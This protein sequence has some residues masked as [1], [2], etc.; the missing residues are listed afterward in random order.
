MTVPSK[1]TLSALRQIVGEPFVTTGE[2][3]LLANARD[4]WPKG[5]IDMRSGKV[6]MRPD[7]VVRPGTPEEVAKILALASRLRIPVTPYAEG[8]GVCGGAVPVRGGISLD[9]KRLN[10]LLEID[11]ES[12]LAWA[13]CGINGEKFERALGARGF[14]LGHFP[15]SIYCS[16]LG[17]WLA[18][19]SAGQCSSKYGKIEDMAEALEIAL[20]DGRLVRQRAVP[21]RAAGPDWRHLF[22]GSEGVLG[23]ITSAAMKI[24][25]LPEGRAFASY[26]FPDLVSGLETFRELLQR[27]AR[28]AVMRLYDEIDTFLAGSAGAGAWPSG[29]APSGGGDAAGLIESFYEAARG[30]GI[31]TPLRFLVGGGLSLSGVWNRLLG[32]VPK[33]YKCILVFEGSPERCEIEKQIAA[34][35]AVA[36]GAKD[37]G[38][39]PAKEWMGRRYAAGYRQSAVYDN[40]AFVDT[41][42]VAATWDRLARLYLSVRGALSRHALVMAH[43]SHAYPEGCSI[44]FTF[45]GAG[46]SRES[47]QQ[48]YAETWKDALAAA[49]SAGGTISHHHGVGLGKQ[50]F[51]EKEHGAALRILRAAK[52][53][54]D[55]AGMMN[56]GKMGMA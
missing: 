31:A 55:P 18:T 7:V 16:T 5:Q 41:L 27:G 39:G 52:D 50:A 33:E 53:F 6:E 8:S 1:K 15:S 51:L 19:R 38:E 54:L 45:L 43:F 22:M 10:Q 26:L 4:C 48:R 47:S 34:E 3:D 36:R 35:L 29:S 9:L 21:A 28:P 17:G 37:L 56:P 14:T 24:H 42:E 44:C 32:L 40:F 2:A 12:Q 11:P 46:V 25:R 20:P 23:V 13:Q 49:H 30:A